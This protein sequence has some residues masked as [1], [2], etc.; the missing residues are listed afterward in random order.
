MHVVCLFSPLWRCRPEPSS[1]PFLFKHLI[2]TAGI[3]CIDQ[4]AGISPGAL[5]KHCSVFH[6]QHL[7]KTSAVLALN[8][9]FLSAPIPD[10][11]TE[12]RCFLWLKIIALEYQ[13]LLESAQEVLLFV[14]SFTCSSFWARLLYPTLKLFSG[15]D[16]QISTICVPDNST[17]VYLPLDWRCPEGR[18]KRCLWY[19][20][21]NSLWSD[22]SES[23]AGKRRGKKP[24]M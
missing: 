13:V 23:T 10:G 22:G 21:H 9:Y 14:F 20:L 1:A 6:T 16:V 7:H 17:L 19:K 2:V 11:S 18:R 5:L 12:G 24:Q 4:T 8:Q 15:I 3:N